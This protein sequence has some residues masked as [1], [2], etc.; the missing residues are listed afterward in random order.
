MRKGISTSVCLWGGANKMEGEG[1]TLNILAIFFFFPFFSFFFLGGGISSLVFHDAYFFSGSWSGL[2]ARICIVGLG[3]SELGRG[4]WWSNH[5]ESSSHLITSYQTVPLYCLK[6]FFWS[7]PGIFLTISHHR[8]KFF[9]VERTCSAAMTSIS[10]RVCRLHD[11]FRPHW[12]FTSVILTEV[13]LGGEVSFTSP[14]TSP[15]M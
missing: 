3:W 4:G 2:L 12:D 11:Y 15:V 5:T 9:R 6:T 10:L 7:T 13:K 8:H 14:F 1:P